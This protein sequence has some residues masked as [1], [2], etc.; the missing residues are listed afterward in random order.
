MHPV[1]NDTKW[2]ELRIAMYELG[3]LS[4]QWRTLDVENAHLSSWDGEWF[5]HFRAGGYRTIQWLEVATS[6]EVQ[7]QA[8]LLNLSK[9]HVPGEAMDSGFRVFGYI[10]DGQAVDY[11]RFSNTSLD[12]AASRRSA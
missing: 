11:L 4:P 8:A 1:M 6:S 5:H 2:D 9:I 10:E 7:R 3:S 12:P